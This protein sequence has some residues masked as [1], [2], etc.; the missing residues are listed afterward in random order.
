MECPNPLLDKAKKWLLSRQT[1]AGWIGEQVLYYWYEEDGEKLFFCCRDKG[2][3][4]TAWAILALN[5]L[6]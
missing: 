4:T 1:Q 6:N 3:I 5:A 2:Q